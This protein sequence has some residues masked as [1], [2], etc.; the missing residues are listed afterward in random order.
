MKFPIATAAFAR[1]LISPAQ[2]CSG[3]TRSAQD[4]YTLLGPTQFFQRS[5]FSMWS[6]SSG[7]MSPVTSVA[8]DTSPPSSPRLVA[9]SQ[10]EASRR[11][12]KLN[13]NDAEALLDLLTS[14]GITCSQLLRSLF[15]PAEADFSNEVK[16][17]LRSHVSHF[18][19]TNAAKTFV[20]RCKSAQRT[21]IKFVIDQVRKES[22]KAS[23]LP[24]ISRPQRGSR[25]DDIR[26]VRLNSAVQALETGLPIT[27]SITQA[28]AGVGADD[29]TPVQNSS[30]A[31]EEAMATLAPLSSVAWHG[32]IRSGRLIR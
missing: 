25:A 24:E 31:V 2:R 5:S 16:T 18:F 1:S 29:D 13:D 10:A 8:S 23:R 22:S 17:K 28:I 12:R 15:D 9:Q 26:T 3:S 11:R 30:T 14:R 21:A 4:P 19:S 20:S 6:P 7:S 32:F 27:F